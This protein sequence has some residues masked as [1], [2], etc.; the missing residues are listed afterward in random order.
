MIIGIDHRNLV[1][2][3]RLHCNCI[4]RNEIPMLQQKRS[5]ER[6]SSDFKN[7]GR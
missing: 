2:Y 3:S 6:K 1:F 7:L 4:R 5:I